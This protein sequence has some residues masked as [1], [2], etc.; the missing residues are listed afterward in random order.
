VKV[1][2]DKVEGIDFPESEDAINDYPIVVLKDAPNAAA[3]QAWVDF[4]LSAQGSDVMTAAGF[5][6]P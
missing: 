5:D 6:K 1:A 4:V 3:A 2:G